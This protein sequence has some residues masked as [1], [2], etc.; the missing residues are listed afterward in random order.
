MLD[1]AA[2]TLNNRHT[3]G[4]AQHHA[5]L[6]GSDSFLFTTTKAKPP[7]GMLAT[8]AAAAELATPAQLAS[9]T[10]AAATNSCFTSPAWDR[11]P[12][13]TT[14]AALADS[15]DTAGATGPTAA[16]AAGVGIDESDLYD[17]CIGGGGGFRTPASRR[18]P[19]EQWLLGARPAAVAGVSH[20]RVNE[21]Q[22]LD[23]PGFETS[24]CSSRLRQMCCTCVTCCYFC[25][26]SCHVALAVL[27]AA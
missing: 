27:C 19:A 4:F 22:A 2:V 12:T 9:G 16:A 10:K 7:G 26:N 6:P 18:P 13:T 8:P 24:A 11:D 1:A 23:W 21:T 17:G 20:S 3:A 14:A 5:A 15:P 25:C